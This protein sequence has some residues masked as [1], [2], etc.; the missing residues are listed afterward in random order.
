MEKLVLTGLM[1]VKARRGH[2]ARLGK[3]VVRGARAK[4]VVAA[5]KEFKG[6]PE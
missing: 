4:L 1:E 3:L 2:K 6:R 5:S